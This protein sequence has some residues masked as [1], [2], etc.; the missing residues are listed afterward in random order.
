MPWVGI[1]YEAI[2]Y[3]DHGDGFNYFQALK[4]ENISRK[5]LLK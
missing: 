4:G 2:P 1:G 5:N 3:A